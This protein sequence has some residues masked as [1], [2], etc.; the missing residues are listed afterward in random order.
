MIE[1]KTYKTELIHFNFRRSVSVWSNSALKKVK[2]PRIQEPKI[3]PKPKLSPVIKYTKH[4]SVDSSNLWTIYKTESL[5][6][7][8]FVCQVPMFSRK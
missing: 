1:Q 2:R 5:C 6:D 3:P 7:V 8:T 4:D